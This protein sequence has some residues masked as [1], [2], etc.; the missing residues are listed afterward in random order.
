MTTCPCCSNQLLQHVRN[1]QVYWFCRNCWQEMPTLELKD[2][3]SS[4]SQQ[5]R[6]YEMQSL[7]KV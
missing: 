5:L 2:V 3:V 4:L 6:M 7:L 1:R